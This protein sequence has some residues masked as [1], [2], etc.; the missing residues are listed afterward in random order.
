MSFEVLY[1]L[2]FAATGVCHL[3]APPGAPPGSTGPADDTRHME[4]TALQLILS[5]IVFLAF[6]TEAVVGF[7]STILTVTLGAHLLPLDRLLPAFVPLNLL[8]SISIIA[9]DPSLVDRQVL[10][11]AVLPPVL[12]GMACGL[13]IFRY[14]QPAAL[15]L[16][17]GVF[18]LI[19]SGRELLKLW[20]GDA[21]AAPL[22]TA[23]SRAVLWG[24]GLIH[25][26]FGSGGPL[27]VYV[28]GRIIEDKRRFRSTLAALWLLLNSI[29]AISFIQSGSLNLGSLK[30]TALFIP[31]LALGMWLGEH[32]HHRISPRA[33]RVLT[34]LI[35]FAAAIVRVARE[36]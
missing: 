21:Q 22:T 2:I 34:W 12:I 32:A 7:G 8:L 6:F 19:L 16:A 25:G 13:V 24:G 1:P 30:L 31:A 14:A 28:V 17:F 4:I 27:I 3:P 10:G 20:S 23:R 29:L 35:L 11:R 18:V 36:I 15:M 9:R 26:M 33:F 5:A